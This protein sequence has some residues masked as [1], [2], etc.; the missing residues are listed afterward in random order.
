M[1]DTNLATAARRLVDEILKP[2]EDAADWKDARPKIVALADRLR[3]RLA[4]AQDILTLM[5]QGKPPPR[6]P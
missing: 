4:H 2:Y 3:H 1:T 6:T 5:E